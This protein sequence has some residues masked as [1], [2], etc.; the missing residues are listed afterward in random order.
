V[1]Q[2]RFGREPWLQ[3]Y[4]SVTLQDCP[5]AGIKNVDILCP[6]FAADCLETLEEIQM[7]NKHLFLEAG[8]ENFNYIPCLNDN[9]PTIS[10]HCAKYSPPTCSAGRNHARLGCGQAGGGGE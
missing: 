8:G 7:E 4:C 6:G 2:S 1:F 5:P 10:T 9:M 3:P